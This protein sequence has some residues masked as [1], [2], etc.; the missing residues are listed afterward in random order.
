MYTLCIIDMQDFFVRPNTRV[1]NN[2]ERE[3]RQAIADRAGILLVEY[4]TCGTTIHQLTKL[5]EEFPHARIYHVTK[6]NDDGSYEILNACY[7]F[8]LDSSKI[9]V[10]GVNTDCCVYQTIIGLIARAPF[11]T[12]EV[13]AD[14][15]NSNWGPDSHYRGIQNIKNLNQCRISNAP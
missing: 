3:I 14:A 2:C 13:V 4:E 7:K 9:K 10:C 5:K 8:G 6:T 1:A 12:I 15:C 11:I